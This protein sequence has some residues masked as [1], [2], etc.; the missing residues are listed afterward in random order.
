MK[1]TK[2]D[3]CFFSHQTLFDLSVVVISV[4]FVFFC[5]PGIH[6]NNDESRM[7]ENSLPHDSISKF[8]SRRLSIKHATDNIN[9]T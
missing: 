8:Q 1:G 3:I 4:V 6:T 7:H 9:I 5:S 2:K